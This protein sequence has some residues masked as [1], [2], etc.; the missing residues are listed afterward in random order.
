MSEEGDDEW[1]ISA[2]QNEERIPHVLGEGA[3]GDP[4]PLAID[5]AEVA[6]PVVRGGVRRVLDQV[7]AEAHIDAVYLRGLEDQRHYGEAPAAVRRH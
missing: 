3:A 6:D 4:L 2:S 7:G 5:C 1:E